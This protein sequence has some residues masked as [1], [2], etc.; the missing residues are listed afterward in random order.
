MSTKSHD[1]LHCCL[2]LRSEVTLEYK[3]GKQYLCTEC[4]ENILQAHQNYNNNHKKDLI[5]GN[6]LNKSPVLASPQQI[7]AY[8]DN[9][10]IGQDEA[11]KT[12][13][14]GIYQHYLRIFQSK[15]KLSED[16]E[17]TVIEKSNIL[18]VGPTGVGKTLLVKT[19]A[20]LL[21]VPFAIA[22]ATVFT[23]A[24]YVGEDV[25][26]VLTRLLQ[27]CDYN[28][29]LAQCGIVY[30]D[31]I[32]KLARRGHNPSITKDV[33]G[34]GVQQGLLKLLEG[35]EALV[36]PHGGRKHPEQALIKINTKDILFICGGA[37]AGIEKIVAKRMN[38]NTIG[39]KKTTQIKTNNLQLLPI[40]TDDLRAFGM[41]PELLG[42][43]PIITQ[44]H[45]LTESSLHSILITPKNSIIKQYQKIFA[46]KG[47]RLKFQAKAIEE[48]AK[49]AFSLQIGARGLRSIVE[50]VLQ[51]LIYNIGEEKRNEIIISANYVKKQIKNLPLF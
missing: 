19:I 36:P 5:Q 17:D 33:G 24:G 4:A 15:T 23:E 7:K 14:V 34:E 37:F 51:E 30:I 3:F 40:N 21:N 26:S 50:Q 9:Y 39:F 29:N 11:K 18:L 6:K 31:E 47:I 42:R 8:T 25:E 27:V 1:H 38:V 20:Q 45:P 22:D 49:T 2:C 48:I 41:I 10:I 35:T 28:V 46:L 13:A 12:L 44:L 16:F 43:L 32:D